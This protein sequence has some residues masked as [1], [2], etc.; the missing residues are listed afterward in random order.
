MLG[1]EAKQYQKRAGRGSFVTSEIIKAKNNCQFQ[2][3]SG[4][5]FCLSWHPND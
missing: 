1:L 2:Q 5:G 3:N 4:F